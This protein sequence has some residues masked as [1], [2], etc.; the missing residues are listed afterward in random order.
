MLC[1]S[2]E[3]DHDVY[4]SMCTAETNRVT[5]ASFPGSPLHMYTHARENGHVRDRACAR[6]CSVTLACIHVYTC[7]QSMS[8]TQAVLETLYIVSHGKCVVSPHLDV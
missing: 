7:T 3:Y 2:V 8:T 6:I 5:V 4:T 1:D